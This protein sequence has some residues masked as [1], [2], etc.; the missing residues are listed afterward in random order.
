MASS[1]QVRVWW[2][3]WRCDPTRMVR[4][5]FPG[6]GRVWNLL[7]ADES[8]PVWEDFA[9]IMVKHNYLFLESAGGTYNCRKIAGSDKWSLHAY[10]VALDLNPRK[11]PFGSPL[12][13]NY[14]QAFID[15][16]LAH[17]SSGHQT[18]MWGG[19]WS[20]PDAMHWQLN[21]PP[22]DIEDEMAI[23]S[24]EAQQFYEDSYQEQKSNLEPGTSPAWIWTL[25]D[26]F[27]NHE[28]HS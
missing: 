3:G 5:A 12:R 4:V 18:F 19:T 13:H 2:A 7:V 26:F 22:G 27:R 10:G 1:Q 17:R 21:V 25:I 20:T 16:V 11:N 14:P 28:D 6:Q 9:A 24:E 15:D 23:L 8:A